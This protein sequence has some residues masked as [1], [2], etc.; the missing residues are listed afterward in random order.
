MKSLNVQGDKRTHREVKF[1]FLFSFI[2][3][4]KKIQFGLW[5]VFVVL[6][7]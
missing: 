5:P 2:N 7:F 4:G 1:N 3:T 6:Q